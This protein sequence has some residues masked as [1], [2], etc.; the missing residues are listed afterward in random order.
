MH[1]LPKSKLYHFSSP[2]PSNAATPLTTHTAQVPGLPGGTQKHLKGLVSET[3]PVTSVSPKTEII[4]QLPLRCKEFYF[5][6]YFFLLSTEN[7]IE[8]VNSL[9]ET[10]SFLGSF[11]KNL[12]STLLG[13]RRSGKPLCI[14]FTQTYDEEGQPT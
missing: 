2:A 5:L 11:S 3:P 4:W 13:W 7:F 9:Q 8:L 1:G 12:I 6:F 14:W 10:H